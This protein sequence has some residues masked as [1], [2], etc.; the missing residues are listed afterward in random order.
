[1]PLDF[2][3]KQRE[4]VR[5][6]AIS[7]GF[8]VSQV[9]SE[10]SASILAYNLIQDDVSGAQNVLIYRCGGKSL[11]VSVV[12]ITNGMLN[13][14]NSVQKELGGDQITDILIE[15]LAQEF[16]RKHKVDPRETKRGKMKLKLNS[17]NVKKI[18]STLDN[19]NC[20]IESLYEGIDFNANISRSRFE[21][22]FG[23]NLQNYL[24]PINEVLNL[25]QLKHSD[26]NK[27]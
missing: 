8:N 21:N 25:V 9:I 17:E 2:G 19:A 11:T 12:L 6:C 5:K 4:F 1:M 13:V 27:V 16:K 3:L 26:I 24:D 18:L 20:Y 23:R 7:A 15:M 14:L 10:T 22:E